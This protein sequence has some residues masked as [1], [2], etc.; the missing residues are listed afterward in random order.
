L[1]ELN[2]V[3]IV[4]IGDDGVASLPVASMQKMQEAEILFGGERHL[5]FFPRHPAEKVP[6]KSNLKEIAEAIREQLGKKR[7]AVIASGDPNF[8]GI[9]KYLIG[10]LGKESVEILPNVSSMQLAFARIRESWDDA[11]FASCHAR[12]IDGIVDLV[13]RNA[14]VGLFT[15]D[16]NTPA[17]IARVLKGHGIPNCA[18]IVCENLGGRDERVTETDRDRLTE[19]TFSP[20]NVLILKRDSNGVE[21]EKRESEIERGSEGEIEWTFGRPEEAFAHRKPKL[22]LITKAEVR[23]ISLAKMRL[24]SCS[25][26]WDI[27][28]GSGSVS[29]E[30]ARMVTA[31]KV[32][33]IE[34]NEEDVGLIK[35]NV[36]RF[37][38]PNVTVLHA[39]AP[40]GLDAL[41]DPDAVFIGGSGSRMADILEV[42]WKRLKEPGHLVVNLA[43]IENL[44]EAYSFFK[45]QGMKPEVTL[46]Q[47][48]RGSEIL[49]LTRFDALNPVFILHMEKGDAPKG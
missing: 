34:K 25:V 12:P 30:A 40:D 19:M 38:T 26:V 14:K 15:D 33:A 2:R 27:G 17:Q 44:A 7:M 1:N 6:I 37:K 45:G 9:A 29:I 16:E 49:D 24:R 22:G 3:L 31:G 43:T 39:K 48:A 18:A 10:K 21:K 32:F 11:V 23:V 47:I 46:V 35:E 36:D 4:G 41:P 5:S 13:R 20:L 42:C 8:Y 28:A